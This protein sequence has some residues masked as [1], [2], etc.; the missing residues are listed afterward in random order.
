[1]LG[2]ACS[3]ATNGVPSHKHATCQTPSNAQPPSK[4]GTAADWRASSRNPVA[5]VG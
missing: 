1:M 5:K 3:W 2:A 4:K